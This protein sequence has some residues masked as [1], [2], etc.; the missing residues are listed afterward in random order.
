MRVGIDARFW[1]QTGVGRYTRNLV[2][3]LGKLDS[4]NRY[5]L[6][7]NKQDYENIKSQI[8]KLKYKNF[9]IIKVNIKWHSI[10]EQVSFPRILNKYKLDLVHFPYFSHPIFYNKPFVVTIHDLIINHFP[11]GKASTLPIAVYS[12]KLLG[13]KQ[14]LSHAVKKS[15]KII[16]PLEF[17]KNDLI[18][19][20]K[21][22][23]SKIEVAAE[24]FD[25]AISPSKLQPTHYNLPT[26]YFL[27][28]GNA[29][30]HKNLVKLIEGFYRAK[31]KDVN[32]VLVGKDDFFYKRL[33]KEKFPNL[34]FLHD[35]SDT[36]LFH[37]Y[38]NSVAAVSASLME[39][40]GLLPL[41]AF[42][43]GTIPVVSS[44]G[45]FREVCGDT[46]IYF[47]PQDANDIASKLVEASKLAKSERTAFIKKGK[48]LLTKF[49]WSKMA[50]QTLH[51]YNSLIPRIETNKS[52]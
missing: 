5:I 25:P 36:E 11:T 13:Y 16:V 40:F 18:R 33:E 31:L 12:L 37:L 42:G 6:F 29:Y 21:V 10:A 38:R 4:K 39:G 49:S 46:A 28:V 45:A 14:V 26:R 9:E 3:N 41:E 15:K 19:T 32:L 30:P 34:I 2:I 50:V 51:T 1:S 48:S 52:E 17:V 44:I 20:L 47:N 27:Y 43:A 7:V 24:G 8:S 23:A 22:P 35:V